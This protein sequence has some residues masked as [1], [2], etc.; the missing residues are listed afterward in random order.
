MKPTMKA[1]NIVD[2]QKQRTLFLYL[3]CS[4]LPTECLNDRL[5]E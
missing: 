5:N 3:N 2:F 4:R 1:K